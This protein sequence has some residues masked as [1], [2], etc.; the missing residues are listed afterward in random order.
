MNRIER[1]IAGTNAGRPGAPVCN[2]G[3]PGNNVGMLGGS[4]GLYQS[5]EK[6]AQTAN[7]TRTVNGLAILNSHGDRISRIEEK[8]T[9]LEHNQALYTSDLNERL[10]KSND[11]L[12][13]MNRGYNEQMRLLKTYIKQLEEKIQRLS[14]GKMYVPV[15]PPDTEPVPNTEP[16]SDAKQVVTTENISLEIVEN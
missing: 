16:V 5:P 13:L 10:L 1:R 8:L 11:K 15:H 3:R 6:R 4:T 9:Y 2:P 7:Q 12:D 14:E